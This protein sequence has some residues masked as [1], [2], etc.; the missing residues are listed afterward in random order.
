MKDKILPRVLL[1]ATLHTVNAIAAPGSVEALASE[2]LASGAN[3]QMSYSAET[4][5]F[6]V[7]VGRSAP[8]QDTP[9]ARNN[10]RER[11]EIAAKHEIA[12]F[13]GTK[14]ESN[15]EMSS[16]ENTASGR[17]EL[18]EFYS[19]L[20][21][22][23]VDQFLKGLQMLS[24]STGRDGEVVVVMFATAKTQNAPDAWVHA[25]SA[26]AKGTVSAIGIDID[27][28]VAEK[29]AL[30]SAIEQV[31]GTMVAGKMTVTDKEEMHKRL[32]TS[33]GALVEEYR[34]VKETKVEAEYRIEVVAKVSRRKI[35]E[36]YRS[37]FKTLNDPVFVIIASDAALNRSFTQYFVD[38]G[39]NITEQA[40]SAD[41]VI[42][43]NGSFTERMN[44]VTGAPGTMLSLSVEIVSADRKTV[45][46]KMT[47]KKS[48]DSE[49]LS[50]KQREE[51]V[52]RAIFDKIHGRLDEALHRMVIKML[53]DAEG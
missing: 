41:Y 30:V 18:V 11:A 46:L 51:E 52:C 49:V 23:S 31:A 21:K 32:S 4:G 24:A 29:K 20:T 47:E 48:K 3:V 7:G 2:M 35:Y 40:D 9:K 1:F 16:R 22:A 27:R 12:S 6:I 5:V 28:G 39:M 53:D 50:R 26:T 25:E 45:L 38:K 34:I 37:F 8:A 33:A 36:S 14:V 17:N 42:R 10:A 15:V 44:P 43:L 19:S 13:L